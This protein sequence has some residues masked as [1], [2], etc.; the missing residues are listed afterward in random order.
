MWTGGGQIDPP[1]SPENTI[2]KTQP[3][4]GERTQVYKNIW[5]PELGEHLKVQYELESPVR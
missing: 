2:Q 4:Q 1:P 3:Y 5:F